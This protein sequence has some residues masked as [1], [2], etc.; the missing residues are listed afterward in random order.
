[1][2][3]CERQCVEDS[4]AVFLHLCRCWDGI[5]VVVQLLCFGTHT[6]RAWLKCTAFFKELA[7]LNLVEGFD[8]MDAEQE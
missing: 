1:M 8:Y 6:T 4:L 2:C 7:L 3:S 5:E